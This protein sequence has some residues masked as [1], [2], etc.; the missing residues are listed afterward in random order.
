MM[1]DSNE[2]L[3]E[4]QV[5]RGCLAGDGES[6]KDFV[7][8]FRQSVYA[9]CYRLLRHH[10]DAEDV[11]Q[12]TFV[13][14]I[15]SLH[16]WDQTRPL[17]PWLMTIASNRCKTA[18]AKRARSLVQVRQET[19]DSAAE[20]GTASPVRRTELAEEIDLC[21]DQLKPQMRECF[22]LFYRQQLSCAEIA[23]RL[24][25][26]EGTIKTWLHRSRM[27]LADA[28]RQRGHG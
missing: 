3:S 13:R 12:D 20:G 7:A 27:H 19:A 1:S 14:A 26:P 24:D 4:V 25:R 18:L 16:H 23:E 6:L 10:E 2:L 11:M 21:L 17:R 28:L 8:R 9:V 22:L 15:R 5:V